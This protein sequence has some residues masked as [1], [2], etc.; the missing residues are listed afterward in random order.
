MQLDALGPA[1]DVLKKEL[2]PESNYD[3]AVHVFG[4]AVNVST[5][6]LGGFCHLVCPVQPACPPCMDQV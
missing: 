1:V 4:K 2:G 6:H 3:Q 5:L